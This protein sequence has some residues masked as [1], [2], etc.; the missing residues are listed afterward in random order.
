M[1]AYHCCCCVPPSLL[2]QVLDLSYCCS[3]RL[4]KSCW[5]QLTAL[6]RLSLSGDNLTG[7]SHVP[8]KQ[9]PS[10]QHVELRDQRLRTKALLGC[11]ALQV[12]GWV[13]EEEGAVGEVGCCCRLQAGKLLPRIMQLNDVSDQYDVSL[14]VVLLHAGHILVMHGQ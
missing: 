6:T 4:P 14:P 5:S 7:A 12:G 11:T 2:L 1:Y 10:L 9:L 8:L 3:R 13:S